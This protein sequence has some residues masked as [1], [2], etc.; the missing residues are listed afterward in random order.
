MSQGRGILIDQVR[1]GIKLCH[2]PI[3]VRSRGLSSGPAQSLLV[4]AYVDQHANSP[5]KHLLGNL[6]LSPC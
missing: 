5:Y 4:E 1:D 6:E 2:E 3:L